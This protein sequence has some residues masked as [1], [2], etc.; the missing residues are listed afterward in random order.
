MWA[1]LV[2]ESVVCELLVEVVRLKSGRAGV[3]CL[4]VCRLDFRIHF[5]TIDSIWGVVCFWCPRFCSCKSCGDVCRVGALVTC[6]KSQIWMT[7]R[8]VLSMC[9]R[10]CCSYLGHT[11]VVI[12]LK[13]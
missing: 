1:S 3:G 9:F 10:L 13:I 7:G 4:M 2:M 12:Y 5:L 11:I 8:M 6:V